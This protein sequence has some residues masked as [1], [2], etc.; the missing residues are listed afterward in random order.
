AVS[1]ILYVVKG[2]PYR[3]LGATPKP[4]IAH[5]CGPR[6]DGPDLGVG[7]NALGGQAAGNAEF[8]ALP[9]DLHRLWLREQRVEACD[10]W[11]G[12]DRRQAFAS[13]CGILCGARG[14]R[15][16]TNTCRRMECV[17]PAP[18]ASPAFPPDISSL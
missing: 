9:R 1:G 16:L 17:A 7:E 5:D 18:Q 10:A 2:A 6:V 12:A 11:L 4:A 15:R 8:L 3:E 13:K 14:A